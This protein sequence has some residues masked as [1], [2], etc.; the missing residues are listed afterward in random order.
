MELNDLKNTWDAQNNNTEQQNLTSK[1]FDQM[2]E[3]KY[4]SKIDKIAYPEIIGSLICLITAVIIGINFNKL[5]TTFLQGVGVLSILLLLTLSIISFISLR[6]L[7]MVAD[8]SKPYAEVLEAFAIQKLKFYKLQKIN[9]TLCYLLLV[10]ITILLLKLFYGRDIT[11]SKY[12][13]ILSF[14]IGYIFLL[15]F[16]TYVFKFY[17]KTLTQTKELLQ[18]LRP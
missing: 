12:F 5:D 1:L 18:E 15:F 11:D 8:L 7:T 3:K 10:T 9:I 14:T 16:S 6:Q 13:W 17:K 4:K 2:T